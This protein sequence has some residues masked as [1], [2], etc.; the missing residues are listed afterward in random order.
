MQHGTSVLLINDNTI[1]H[2]ERLCVDIQRVESLNEHHAADAGH[3]TALLGVHHCAKLLLHLF[4]DVH[5]IGVL[6]VAG[7]KVVQNVGLSLIL[8]A[9]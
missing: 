7:S 4:L 8:A 6:E 2:N 5:G 9:E 3:T 1:D